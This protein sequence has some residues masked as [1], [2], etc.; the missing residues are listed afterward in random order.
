MALTVGT[1]TTALS[2]LNNLRKVQNQQNTLYNQLSSGNRINSAKDDAAGLQISDRLLSQLNGLNQGNRNANDAIAFYQTADGALQG[3]SDSLQ[4]M[5][6]LAVQSANGTLS[7]E[8]RQALQSEMNQLSAEVTRTAETTRFNGE[9]FLNGAASDNGGNSTMHVGANSQ[10]IMSS[11]MQG[12]FTMQQ[13]LTETSSGDYGNASS[14]QAA[15]ASAQTLTDGNGQAYTSLDIST[16][17]GAEDA[18]AAIDSMIS[19]VDSARADNGAMM[20]RLESTINV[21]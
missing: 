6:D 8:D 16:Q 13:M 15:A 11:S 18:I 10:D 12:G 5:R 9:T 14:V 4:R 3:T 2:G 7:S 1:N 17:A 20:N 19:Y 21:Q